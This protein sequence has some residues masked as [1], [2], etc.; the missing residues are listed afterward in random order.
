M[1]IFLHFCIHVAVDKATYKLSQSDLHN[2]RYDPKIYFA[3]VQN[4]SYPRDRVSQ[5]CHFMRR[6]NIIL[7]LRRYSILFS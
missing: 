7:Q 4:Y 3:H 2:N 1:L 6:V 5:K